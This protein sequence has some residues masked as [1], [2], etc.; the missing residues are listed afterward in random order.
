MAKSMKSFLLPTAGHYKDYMSDDQ[1]DGLT[2]VENEFG[3]KGFAIFIKLLQKICGSS[4][5]YYIKWNDRVGSLFAAELHVSK[6]LV[7]ETVERTISEGLFDQELYKNY[8]ILTADYIQRN[9]YEVKK[10]S[11]YEIEEAYRLIKVTQNSENVCKKGQNA[12]KTGQN[13]SKTTL[14]ECNRIECNEIERKSTERN[15]VRLTQVNLTDEERS[16]L[17]RLADRLTVDEYIKSIIKWQ[18]EHHKLNTKPYSCIKKWIEQDG[19]SQSNA[20]GG[21]STDSVEAFAASIDLSKVT[22]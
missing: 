14:I 17:E 16:E 22:T 12:S 7:L 21:I 3:L 1:C 10:R 11:S 2:M 15:D 18:Q 13:A 5:G 19:R 4:E 20:E 9:W 8:Q 6:G